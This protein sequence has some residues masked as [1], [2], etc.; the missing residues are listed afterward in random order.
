MNIVDFT[1][2]LA[3]VRGMADNTVMAYRRDLTAF[4]EFVEKQ[5]LED[6]NFV[7]NATV[8]EYLLFLKNQGKSKATVNRKLA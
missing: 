8:I 4:E 6:L 7:S 3:D 2:Y 1:S 5:G